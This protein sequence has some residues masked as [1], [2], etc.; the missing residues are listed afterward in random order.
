MQAV[1]GAISSLIE[2]ISDFSVWLY[3]LSMYQF[4]YYSVYISNAV[5]KQKA[6]LYDVYDYVVAYWILYTQ[7]FYQYM[8]TS[9]LIDAYNALYLSDIGYFLDVFKVS[10]LLSAFITASL[11]RFAIRRLPVVG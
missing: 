7:D 2:A 1:V 4:G 10:T 9:A 3:E 8:N 11:I 5:D 6:N